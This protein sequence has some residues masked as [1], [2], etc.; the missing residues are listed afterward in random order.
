MQ[1]QSIISAY[2]HLNRYLRSDS[3]KVKALAFSSYQ[4]RPNKMYHKNKVTFKKKSLL[5]VPCRYDAE[6]LLEVVQTTLNAQY[7]SE[8]IR[9]HPPEG[10]I[11]QRKRRD[12]NRK[13]YHKLVEAKLPRFCCASVKLDSMLKPPTNA[14]PQVTVSSPV[15]I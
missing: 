6:E 2:Y 9:E 7:R 14:L 10:S 4:K 5:W 3:C 15:N 8:G 1:W 11:L 13:F 12:F